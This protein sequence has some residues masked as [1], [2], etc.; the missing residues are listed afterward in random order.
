MTDP[1]A[2]LSIM[3]RTGSYA[4]Q[5]AASDKKSEQRFVLLVDADGNHFQKRLGIVCSSAQVRVASTRRD[6]ACISLLRSY[7]REHMW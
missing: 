4:A 6:Q 2:G 1:C 5:N 3:M 7:Q